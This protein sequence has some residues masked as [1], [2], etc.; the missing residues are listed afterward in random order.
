MFD[1]ALPL[2]SVILPLTVNVWTGGGSGAGG[3]AEPV[4][5][6]MFSAT[7]PLVTVTGSSFQGKS[8]VQTATIQLPAA[9][10][11]NA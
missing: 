7:L 6:A 11:S 8:A 5:S 3:G 4:P 9:T 2:V 10:L 1:S